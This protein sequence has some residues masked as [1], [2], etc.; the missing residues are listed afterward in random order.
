MGAKLSLFS[1]KAGFIFPGSLNP[2]LDVI[3]LHLRKVGSVTIRPGRHL[4]SPG[5]GGDWP[6]SRPIESIDGKYTLS[7]GALALQR[8]R[9][10]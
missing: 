5:P 10:R 1:R 2:D 6:D 9:R 3:E 8:C 7:T 4:M